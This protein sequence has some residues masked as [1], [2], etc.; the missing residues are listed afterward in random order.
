MRDLEGLD[1]VAARLLGRALCG[2][3]IERAADGEKFQD[4]IAVQLDP[5]SERR[6]ETV[7]AWLR[8]EA[9]RSLAHLDHPEGFERPN[10]V[11]DADAADAEDVRQLAL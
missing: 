5:S 2:E 6:D 1:V 10:R 8:H 9:A 4:L 3:L 7:G 11:P